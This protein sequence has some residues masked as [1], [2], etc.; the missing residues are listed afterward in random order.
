[1]QHHDA[2]SPDD[3]RT[4]GGRHRRGGGAGAGRHVR[5]VP[6]FRAVVT[7]AGTTTVV[8]TVVAGA[9]MASRSTPDDAGARPEAAA[10]SQVAPL[11]AGSVPSAVP[12]DRTTTPPAAPP[13]V[14]ASASASARP[15]PVQ[16][17]ATTPPAPRNA[18]APAALAPAVGKTDQYIAQVV[19]LANDERERAGC[20]PLRSNSRLRKA[21][22]AHANDMATR[23]YY[24][25]RSPEGRDAGDRIKA[26]GYAW[27]SWAEN[28]HR[29]PKTP[30]KA[31]EDWM[32]SDGHRRNILNC[33]FK[34]I[35]VGVALASNGPWWVQNF[36]TGR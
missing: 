8:L 26:A 20:G 33:S 30:A 7:V 12:S 29:G 24:E 34:D 35:G 16:Q 4:D 18:A 6:S 32:N 19:S 27:D 2:R 5:R 10:L 11:H 15:T 28:I 13:S 22:Q 9:Y 21:A 1:M 25:H 14:S 17:S 23:D 31:M 3:R 36:G